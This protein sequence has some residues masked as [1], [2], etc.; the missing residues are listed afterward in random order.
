MLANRRSADNR[1][2]DLCRH[3]VLRIEASGPYNPGGHRSSPPMN[4]STLRALDRDLDGDVVFPGHPDYGSARMLWNAMIDKRPAVI[5]RCLSDSDV[6]ACI[7]FATESGLALA[8]RGGGH[9][10]AGNSSCDGGLVVDLSR[11][12]QVTVDPQSRRAHVA[13]GAVWADVDGPC[14]EHGLHTTGGVVSSTG[15]AGLTLGGGIGWLS[16]LCGHTCDNLVAARVVT[17]SGEVVTASEREN[18]DLLWGLG[19]GGGNFG[20][21]T[22]FEFSL[23]P[24][25][26]VV[27]GWLKFPWDSARAALETYRDVMDEAPDRLSAAAILTADQA[28]GPVVALV[29]CYVGRAADADRWISALR[30]P[31]PL[32]DDVG[33]KR[34][35]EHQ[36]IYETP[37]PPRMG[38]YW[39]SNFFRRL[40][41]DSIDALIGAAELDF[42]PGLVISLEVL[43]GAAAR[44][45][46]D[47]AAFAHRAEP[48]NYLADAGWVDPTEADRSIDWARRAS[49]LMEPHL[50]PGNY[51]NYMSEDD[52]RDP[53]ESIR[54][55]YGS[56]GAARLI[57]LK[58][59]Y[60]P[61]N[62]FRL[63]HNI[64][65]SAAAFRP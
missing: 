27:G 28:L 39:K 13:G 44:V 37:P 53:A 14:S 26:T 62:V 23:H 18:P 3:L 52:R 48:Y 55:A 31:G 1:G 63:N 17:A 8:I 16:R 21:V 57:A 43:G 46:G 32:F 7:R 56:I 2:L 25:T 40:D 50:S 54:R 11:M 49:R 61:G 35:L 60:D 29:P 24:V 33:E 9:N 65:P 19:G 38:H 64:P 12:R 34:Y 45:G 58:D 4:R 10:V 15:V 22:R 59:R 20:V 41:G 42:R 5:V 36:T 47:E 51:V 30:S 6:A